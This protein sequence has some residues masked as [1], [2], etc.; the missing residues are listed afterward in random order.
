MT[1]HGNIFKKNV[2]I[3]TM[4]LYKED[5]L[6]K[7]GSWVSNI[8]TVDPHVPLKLYATG[9][10]SITKGRMFVALPINHPLT[11]QEKEKYNIM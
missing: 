10:C 9:E 6:R 2:D 1:F 3:K 7:G 11:P 4:E 8:Q 5:I